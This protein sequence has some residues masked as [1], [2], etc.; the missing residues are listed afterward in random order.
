MLGKVDD[1]AFLANPTDSGLYMAA[2]VPSLSRKDN[3]LADLD[4]AYR[5]ALRTWPELEGLVGRAKRVGPIR[6]MSRWH[7]FFR[8][9]AGPGWVL[10][11]DAGHF[12]DP[13]PG[14]GISDAFRQ[15]AQLAPAIEQALSGGGADQVLRRWWEWR[16]QDAWEMYWFAHDMGSPG[17]T[18]PV[19]AE[20]Q[21]RIAA[22]EGLTENLIRVLNHDLSPSRLVPL[23]H[24]LRAI[25][26]ALRRHTGQRANVIRESVDLARQQMRQRK[27]PHGEPDDQPA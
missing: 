4:G 15:A 12:K 6:V 14:Q 22:D 10:V 18:R 26:V 20:I 5:S 13:T 7:G 17:P 9:S 3:V 11:G 23:P 21:G 19:M 25:A 2:V 1:N 27:S 8:R 24:V 16:D